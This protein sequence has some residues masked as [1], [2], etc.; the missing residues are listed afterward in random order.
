MITPILLMVAIGYSILGSLLTMFVGRKLVSLNNLQLKK[1][2][3]FRYELI[4]VREYADSI[5]ILRGE[6]K[7][8]S[9]L[10]RRLKE[11]VDNFR[12]HRLGQPEPRI[13]HDR[14]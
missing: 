3:N 8:K 11:L 9:R 6:K 5:A 13:L 4:H 14:I 2:A 10:G 12:Q 7:Q 1:E